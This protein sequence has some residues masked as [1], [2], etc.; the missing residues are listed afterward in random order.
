MARRS[1]DGLRVAPGCVIPETEITWRFTTSGGPGGQHANRSATQ[2]EATFDVWSSRA[3]SDAQ[4]R[5]LADRLGPVVRVTAADHRSQ[6]RNRGL[7]L[8][9]LGERLAGALT[10][11]TPRRGTRPT[12]AAKEK[13]LSR[14]RRRSEKKRLRG[15]VRPGDD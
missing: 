2:A 5:R 1:G 4:K 13:R 6:T 15:R 11:E 3:L 10:E 9:R 7:A 8:D 14:K 12:R